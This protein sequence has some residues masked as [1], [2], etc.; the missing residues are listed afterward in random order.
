M[1]NPLKPF[2]IAFK[3][4][5]Y[6]IYVYTLSQG[7]ISYYIKNLNRKDMKEKKK[8]EQKD[9]NKDNNTSNNIGGGFTF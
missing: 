6:D 7:G 4:E 2:C 3:K 8:E 9:N 1:D 5:E